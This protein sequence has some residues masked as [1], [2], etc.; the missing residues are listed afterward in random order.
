[1]E[2]TAEKRSAYGKTILAKALKGRLCLLTKALT[3]AEVGAK[4]IDIVKEIKE[5]HILLDAITTQSET[6]RE[7]KQETP[8]LVVVWGTSAEHEAHNMTQT[9]CQSHEEKHTQGEGH[10]KKA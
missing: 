9:L 2:K 4:G 5:L 3:E 6:R 1:M 7:E 10:G 8:P